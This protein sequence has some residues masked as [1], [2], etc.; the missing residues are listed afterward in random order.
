M[1]LAANEGRGVS[2][3]ILAAA[4]RADVVVVCRRPFNLPFRRALR[5]AAKRLVF[6][7]D[8]AIFI[9]GEGRDSSVRRRRFAS[10]AG[11]ADEVWAGNDHL[12]ERSSAH[13]DH[14]RVLPTSVD[15]HRYDVNDDV[16][17]AK[18]TESF[19]LVWIGSSS[20]RKYLEATMPALE[21]A[22]AHVPNLRLKIVAD[23][24][25]PSERLTT[26]AVPWSAD[27]EAAA[28]VSSHVGLAPMS[29][30]PWTRGKCGLKVL[31]YMA[32]RL[33]V[34]A[35]NAGVH[36]QMIEP[37]G[38]GLLVENERQWV[39]AIERLAQDAGLRGAWGRRVGSVWRRITR[40]RRWGSAWWRRW[41]RCRGCEA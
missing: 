9:G 24:D 21:A 15:P 17:A 19:D 14:V 25:L 12:A 22:A 18:P 38:T 3:R 27:G 33:P 39:E 41:K 30:D 40:A 36:L 5:A 1:H 2:L 13:N 6:D 20:T 8:D 32:A 26:V 29:D 28:L 16:S 4:R 31:Q 7:L 34:I 35:A 11:L 10:I 37:G 23:F